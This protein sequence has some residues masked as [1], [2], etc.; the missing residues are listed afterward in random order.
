MH[1]SPSLPATCCI[2]A[3]RGSSWC[4][5]R[6]VEE[7]LGGRTPERKARRKRPDWRKMHEHPV[8]GCANGGQEAAWQ[9]REAVRTGSERLKSQSKHKPHH[10][11][12]LWVSPGKAQPF[13][14]CLY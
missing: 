4:L 8:T 11:H 5:S 7:A 6:T 1:D 3:S 13:T 2:L 14:S 10:P 12:G 9:S